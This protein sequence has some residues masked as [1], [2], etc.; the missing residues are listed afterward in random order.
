MVNAL[1]ALPTCEKSSLNSCDL[2]CH[3]VKH[4]HDCGSALIFGD[5]HLPRRLRMFRENRPA[6][7][8]VVPECKHF[9]NICS[10]MISD[11]SKPSTAIRCFV[12]HHYGVKYWTPSIKV[13][14]QIAFV[15]VRSQTP[16]KQ[17]VSAPCPAHATAMH[18]VRMHLLLL[19]PSCFIYL[20]HGGVYFYYGCHTGWG[21][22]VYI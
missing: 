8:G 6:V 11:K 15:G 10:L 5:V 3:R 1:A 12:S 9:L 17:S 21:A 13:C 4:F 19:H 14:P 18:L 7:N 22:E 20:P 16:Y 2:K